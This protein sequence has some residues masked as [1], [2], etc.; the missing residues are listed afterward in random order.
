[1]STQITLNVY[2]GPSVQYPSYEFI[3]PRRRHMTSKDVMEIGKD[4]GFVHDGIIL[5]P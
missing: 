1:M 4:H 5:L 3:A 2:R